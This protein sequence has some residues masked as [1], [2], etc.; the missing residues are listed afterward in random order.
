MYIEHMK[1]FNISSTVNLSD[2]FDT[3]M[4]LSNPMGS[5]SWNNRFNLVEPNELDFLNYKM[6]TKRLRKKLLKSSNKYINW[7]RFHISLMKYHECRLANEIR[8]DIDNDILA[9]IDA[10]M[11][12]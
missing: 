7:H 6:A 9:K 2:I 5:P 1:E 11:G 10:E 8:D 12:E 3:I 4:K